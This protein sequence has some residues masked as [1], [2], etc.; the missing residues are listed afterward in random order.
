MKE[1]S[2]QFFWKITPYKQRREQRFEKMQIQNYYENETNKSEQQNEHII[3]VP[4]TQ[5]VPKKVKENV[6]NF[7]R[8][9]FFLHCQGATN[10]SQLKE[11][12]ITH[13]GVFA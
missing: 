8:V 9:I 12:L 10:E 1:E 3:I 2:H 7:A 5:H 11:E 13:P 4:G 6:C